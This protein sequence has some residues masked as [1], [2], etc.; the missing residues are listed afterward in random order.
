[1]SEVEDTKLARQEIAIWKEQPL[2][3]VLLK[4]VESEV[5]RLR[6]KLEAIE[7][8]DVNVARLQAAI[9]MRREILEET[10]TWLAR[11]EQNDLSDFD[12]MNPE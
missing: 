12:D 2:T 9:T 1:M 3:K 8:T 11:L 7:T 10:E 6:Q 4:N 5:E